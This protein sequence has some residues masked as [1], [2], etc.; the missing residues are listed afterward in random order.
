[1]NKR[2]I[3]VSVIAIFGIIIAASVIVTSFSYAPEQ[4]SSSNVTPPPQKV[5]IP[6]T[7]TT[8]PS[9][10]THAS[11]DISYSN[12]TTPREAIMRHNMF[13]IDMYNQITK[14]PDQKE[15]N[16][17]FSPF[18]MYM[19]FSFL[20]EGARDKT[21]TE[22]EHVFGFYS[23]TES[24]HEHISQTIASIHR[25]DPYA[26]LETA[27]ALWLAEGFVPYD[28]YTSIVRDIYL[29]DIETLDF[30]NSKESA[31]R[32]NNWAANKTHDKITEI[33]DESTFPARTVAVLNNAIYFKGTW[34]TQFDPSNTQTDEFWKTNTIKDSTDFM[35]NQAFFN[36]TES[37]GVQVLQMPYEGDRLSML[38]FL[39][40]ERNNIQ[41]LENT[42]SAE[43][44]DVWRE[45]LYS[46]EVIV[47][48]PK[49]KAETRYSLVDYFKNLGMPSAFNPG[50]DFSGMVD[51][52]TLSGSLYVL[53]AFQNAFVD[54]NEEGTEAAA[55]TTII[56][57]IDSAPPRPVQFTANHPF[58]FVIQDNESGTILFM[59]KF[60][61][62]NT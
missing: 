7:Q 6:V 38:V 46:A 42:I 2:I 1:M 50:A 28:T 30:A 13:A 62:P 37:D 44:I 40:S 12:P 45:H 54:V 25:D 14:D 5:D 8:E 27:N 43:T 52:T 9:T 17:F 61:A 19:A 39:P 31:E 48:M 35:H 16:V 53:D 22:M 60:S 33:V 32:I 41:Q 21:A 29:A 57:G 4:D 56:A 3:S 20:Y 10:P 49:F 18:S 23:D 59:G 26:I 51:L 11:T 34:V 15:K 47:S 24:R 55:I 36:Y 58:I